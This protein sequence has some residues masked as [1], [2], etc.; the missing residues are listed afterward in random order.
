MRLADEIICKKVPK[1]A[2]SIFWL[3]QAGFVIKD[4][5]GRTIAIDPYLTDACERIVGF[6]RLSPKL[7]FA[8]ELQVDVLF[9]T[10]DHP[11][12]FDADAVP[13]L[14]SGRN[15]LFFGSG[16]AAKKCMDA[17]ISPARVKGMQTGENA[18]IGWACFRA[19][20]A[21]HGELVPDAIG[22]VI[23]LEGITVYYTGDTAYRPDAMQTALLAKPDMIILPINGAF[24]NLDAREAAM[25]ARDA[26][27]R[28]AVPC[29][30]W[31]FAQHGGDPQR[32][33]E[34][35][36]VI[37]PGCKAKILRHGENFLYPEV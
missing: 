18:D 1:N 32:F 24:G 2:I 31:T 23:E 19:V 21:D 9:C 27:A 14:M 12:H 15:T 11:D 5:A 36:T 17:G 16:S 10:H 7:V 33:E 22:V 30:F 3:G 8:D 37:A 4:S 25:L 28:M 20:Y 29:H 26:Q 34:E 35:M 6:K 13:V